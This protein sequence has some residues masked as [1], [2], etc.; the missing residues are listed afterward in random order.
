MREFDVVSGEQESSDAGFKMGIDVLKRGQTVGLNS[1]VN[2][3]AECKFAGVVPVSWADSFVVSFQCLAVV[4]IRVSH[5]ISRRIGVT[6][7][8]IEVQTCGAGPMRISEAA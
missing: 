6:N 1:S 5:S 2:F 7:L 8:R 4:A 3:K